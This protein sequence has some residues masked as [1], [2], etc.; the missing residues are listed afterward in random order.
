MILALQHAYQIVLVVLCLLVHPL[1]Q[2]ES[3]SALLADDSDVSTEQ[4]SE[5]NSF[6]DL[7]FGEEEEFLPVEEAY[8]LQVSSS[9]EGLQLSWVITDDYFLYGE[10]F[11][12]LVNDKPVS[13]QKPDGIIAFDPIFEKDLEKHFH[14]VNLTIGAD[15]LPKA[16]RVD[17]AVTSQ[18]C[19]VAG[20]C[21][22]PYTELFAINTGAHEVTALGS[23]DNQPQAQPNSGEQSRV[24][25]APA[26]VSLILFMLVSALIGGSILNLMPCVL[27]VL[28]LKALSLVNSHDKHHLQG[29]SYTAGAV[30]TFVLIAGVL[31]AVRSAGEAVGWGFQLQSP[32]FVTLLVFLF[33]IMGLSLSGFMTLGS[34]WMNAGNNLTEGKGLKQSYFTGVLA[35]VV[36]SPCTAPFMAPA[37]GFAITQPWWL[38]ISIFAALG[39][40]MALPLLVLSFIPR[41]GKRLP[42]PG[43]WMLTFKQA[44]AFP[45]YFTAIWLLWVLGRQLGT[46]AAMIV[47]YASLLTVFIYWL[48]QKWRLLGSFASAAVIAVALATSWSI[49]QR[50]PISTTVQAASVWEPYDEQRLADLRQQGKAVFINMTADWC[51]TCLANEKVVF[52][53][54]RL[55]EMEAKGIVLVKGDWTNYDPRITRLLEKHKRGGV[56]L[57]LLFPAE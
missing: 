57:Y 14:Q 4:Y 39:L 55:E 33:F 21:Y 49:S 19:A 37:L 47:V 27:P 31:L 1:S 12:V 2:A 9:D 50:S 30:S 45:L 6:S 18:G 46:D 56:P 41:L 35:A 23:P 42:Q 15:Q 53:E 28:S 10:K 40:G 38:A 13:Y 16:G 24:A 26:S 3:L 22:P 34:R 29:L 5:S 43:A 11:R 52:T 44:M 36:A 48:G 8:Q 7:D 25:Y 17:L 32:A 20:L 54:D 51:I